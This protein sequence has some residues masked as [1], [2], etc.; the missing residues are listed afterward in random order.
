VPKKPL[1]AK[2]VSKAKSVA[3]E[4]LRQ[5]A[6]LP[7]R[8]QDGRLEVCLVTTRSTGRWTLPKGWPIKGRKDFTAARIEA[9]QEAGVT[10]TPRRKP[11]GS[12]L[13]WKRRAEHFDLVNVAVYPLEATKALA[14]W[15]EQGE[16]QVRWVDPGDA[17]LV[18]EEPG[19]AALLGKLKPK[20]RAKFAKKR[21]V[22]APTS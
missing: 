13:Y 22:P 6:A 3:A 8:E 16:R 1:G 17:S 14:T 10:G 5:V 21:V 7:M 4:A 11:I 12:F 9:E 18:V 2:K 19:L 20:K 15:K